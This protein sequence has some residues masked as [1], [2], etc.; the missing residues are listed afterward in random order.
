MKPI[1]HITWEY[2]PFIVGALSNFLYKIVT[3]IAKIYPIVVVTRG[4]QDGEFFSNGVKIYKIGPY[5]RTSPHILAFAYFLNI[6]LTRGASNVIHNYGGA[7]LIHSHDWISSISAFYIS[8]YFKCPLIISIYST[9]IKRAG[10][11]S[12]LLNMS[13]FDIEKACM[14]RANALIVKDNEMKFHIINNY[15]INENKIFIAKNYKEILN[16]YRGFIK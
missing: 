1:I 12:T 16:V 11:L 7:S 8:K 5:S 15:G 10:S 4:D 13:I 14:E 3:E 9:E 2:P 6:D